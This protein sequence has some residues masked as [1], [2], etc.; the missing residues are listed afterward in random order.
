M[1]TVLKDFLVLFSV[2]VRKKITIDE[3]LSFTDSASGIRLPDCSKLAINWKND[4]D[5]TTFRR[6]FVSLIKFSCW[7][8]FHVNTITGSGVMKI[9]FYK[10]W[11]EIRKSEIPPSEFCLI[12]GDWGKLGIP[13][14]AR[15]S[16]IK[17]YWIPQ[18]AKVTAFNVPE[19]L[20][21]NQQGE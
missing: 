19:L 21:E 12:C 8:K 16:L 10:G 5:V 9:F 17:C 1:R 13:N 4:I 15:T 3:N 2:F 14:L 7:S 6:C 20:R 18:N 11:T